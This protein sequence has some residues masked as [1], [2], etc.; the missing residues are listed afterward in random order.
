MLL[1]ELFHIYFV[2]I[3]THIICSLTGVVSKVCITLHKYLNRVL[4]GLYTLDRTFV[5]FLPSNVW[6]GYAIRLTL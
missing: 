6:Q 2:R 5:R 3:S 4:C 1:T